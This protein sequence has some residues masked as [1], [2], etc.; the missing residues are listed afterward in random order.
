MKLIIK[1]Q[2]K[3]QKRHRTGRGG[4]R[5]DPSSKDKKAIK[6]DLMQIKPAKP[7]KA[8][9]KVEIN[10]FFQTPKSWSNAKRKRHEGKPRPKKPDV[11]NIEKIYLD[12]ANGMLWEDDNQVVEIQT[13]KFYSEQPCTELKITQLSEN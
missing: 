3:S 11:D 4:H 13:R 8:P 2:P 1:G 9:V 12:S 6:K 10:A 7:I 5:Y